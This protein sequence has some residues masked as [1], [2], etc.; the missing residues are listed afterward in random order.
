MADRA[1]VLRTVSRPAGARVA[2]KDSFKARRARG[3]PQ[4]V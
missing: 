3:F 4:G 1:S 2:E